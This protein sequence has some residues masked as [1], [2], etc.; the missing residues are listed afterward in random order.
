MQF[1]C[2]RYVLSVCSTFIYQYGMFQVGYPEID[3]MLTTEIMG[4][5]G[6]QDDDDP[7]PGPFTLKEYCM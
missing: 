4:L 5:Y 3:E 7:T 1:P 2:V 6:L